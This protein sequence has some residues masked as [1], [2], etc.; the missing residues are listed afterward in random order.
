MNPHVRV[1]GHPDD[2]RFP[3]DYKAVALAARVMGVALAFNNSSLSPH[4]SRS[5]GIGYALSLLEECQ[6]PQEL[7]VN[8][9]RMHFEEFVNLAVVPPQSP[10]QCD[11]SSTKDFEK[12]L[13]GRFYFFDLT[14]RRFNIRLLLDLTDGG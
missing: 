7:V 6:F 3:F 9:N 2:D 8:A 12:R 10:L 4:S 5:G 14:L 1:I 11:L 13:R